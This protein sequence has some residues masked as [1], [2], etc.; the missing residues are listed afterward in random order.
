MG[1]G[2]AG[3]NTKLD[4]A[5]FLEPLD[6]RCLAGSNRV[7]IYSAKRTFHGRRGSRNEFCEHAV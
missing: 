5:R 1:S 6:G 4:M 3:E 7:A 2:I